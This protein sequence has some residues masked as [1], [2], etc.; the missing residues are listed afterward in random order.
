MTVDQLLEDLGKAFRSFD[1]EA[2]ESWASVFHHALGRFEGDKLRDAHN[3]VMMAFKPSGRTP[4]PVPLE[5]LSHLPDPHRDAGRARSGPAL[6]FKRHDESQF[7][8][9]ADWRARQGQRVSNGVPQVLIALS[10]AASVVAN[11]Q[12]WRNDDAPILLSETQIKRAWHCAISQE[13]HDRHGPTHR[14]KSE[15]WWQQITD[16]AQGWGFQAEWDD[17]N[18]ATS[19]F[20]K[21]PADAEEPL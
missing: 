8:L 9:M 15:L 19:P 14:L 7:R 13:R 12:A 10:E 6:D 3:A 5:Y 4:F 16:V 20:K 2:L 18:S 11:L 21:Q 1:D 17:W